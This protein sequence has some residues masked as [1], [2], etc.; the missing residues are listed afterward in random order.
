[1]RQED[2]VNAPSWSEAWGLRLLVFT[3]IGLLCWLD[4]S[5]IPAIAFALAWI[6][7]YPLLGAVATGT[8]RLPRF[9]EPVHPVEPVV[10]RWA[11]VGVIKWL[12][13]TRAWSTLVGLEPPPKAGSRHELLHRVELLTKGA[14]ACHGAAFL[15]ALSWALFCL[16]IG[17]APAAVWILAFNIALN[18]YPVMLQRS[19]RWRLQQMPPAMP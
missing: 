5:P 9:L 2:I 17:G 3:G 18:G 15:F 1:M 10:Y 11:G 14:E 16:A 19:N 13:T 6:P 12:V 4:D 7:N 8:V